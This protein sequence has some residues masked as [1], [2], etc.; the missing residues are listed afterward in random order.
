MKTIMNEQV[1][2]LVTKGG[3]SRGVDNAMP[4]NC[5]YDCRLLDTCLY[6]P[7]WADKETLLILGT[8]RSKSCP[9]VEVHGADMRGD[10][11]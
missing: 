1:M 9:L 10:T 6:V 4:E 8:E 11:E 2:I 5:L 7:R 3:L